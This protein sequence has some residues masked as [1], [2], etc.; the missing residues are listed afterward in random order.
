MWQRDSDTNRLIRVTILAEEG[1]GSTPPPPAGLN[2]RKPLKDKLRPARSNTAS[3]V[4]LPTE[5]NQ[6]NFKPG[7]IQLLPSFHGLEKENPYLHIKGFEEACLTCFDG[8]TNEET[9]YLKLFPFSLKDKAKNWLNALPSKSINNWL[10]LQA[11]FLK[12]FFPLHR[13]QGLQRQIKNFAQLQNES[14]YATWERYNELLLACPH[15][16]FEL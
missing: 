1:Q 2:T 11:E 3:A 13:T 15:H 16:G 9:V 14:L 7:V 6:F 8:K 4:V 10:E 5:T 12:K